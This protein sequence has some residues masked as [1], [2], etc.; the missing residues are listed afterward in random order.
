LI[1]AA[2]LAVDVKGEAPVGVMVVRLAGTRV[3][4]PLTPKRG[5]IMPVNAS[6]HSLT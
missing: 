1:Q 2:R 6:R 5:R 3:R 4:T